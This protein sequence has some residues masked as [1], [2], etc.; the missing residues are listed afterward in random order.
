MIVELDDG[1]VGELVANRLKK[2]EQDLR[3]KI[4]AEAKAKLAD[5]KAK[6]TA[7]VKGQLEANKEADKFD[8]S[9]SVSTLRKMRMYGV[10]TDKVDFEWPS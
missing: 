8:R 10:Q 9:Q 3:C 1:K 7:E 6:I 4:E 2:F 5:A